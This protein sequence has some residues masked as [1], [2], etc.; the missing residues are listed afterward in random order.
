MI[1]NFIF[2]WILVFCFSKNMY[3]CCIITNVC[4]F[5]ALALIFRTKVF[6]I[7]LCLILIIML[8][9]QISSCIRS[10]IHVHIIN[11]ANYSE[12][13]QFKRGIAT[14]KLKGKSHNR[15]E[16]MANKK[17]KKARREKKSRSP[18]SSSSYS[19]TINI[20]FFQF[21]HLWTFLFLLRFTYAFKAS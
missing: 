18:Y 16:R 20:F 11:F 21:K 9:I 19:Y 14:I 12:T 13:M 6:F 15:H 3:L 1:S 5:D 8:H 4:G 7:N 17:K 2:L 10:K